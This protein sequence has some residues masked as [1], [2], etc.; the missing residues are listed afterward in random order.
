M[1]QS[2]PFRRWFLGPKI[3]MCR[4][5][6]IGSIHCICVKETSESTLLFDDWM[7]NRDDRSVKKNVK[8]Q[9]KMMW[10]QRYET[11]IKDENM[12][13]QCDSEFPTH[14]TCSLVHTPV[15]CPDTF[16]T[17]EGIKISITTVIWY[18]TFTGGTSHDLTIWGS[19]QNTGWSVWGVSCQPNVPWCR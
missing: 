19:C 12:K 2:C 15:S 8:P 5:C 7:D 11:T 14:Y 4:V 6:T 17:T 18:S 13:P 10:K 9:S 16:G 3:P 1:Y